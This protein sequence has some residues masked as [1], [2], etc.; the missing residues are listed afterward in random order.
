MLSIQSH[1]QNERLKLQDDFK[2]RFEG[3]R[4]EIERLKAEK[5]QLKDRIEEEKTILEK[6]AEERYSTLSTEN[7]RLKDDLTKLK[8]EMKDTLYNVS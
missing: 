4:C 2:K 7:L 1:E 5:K 8:T 6:N 3:N